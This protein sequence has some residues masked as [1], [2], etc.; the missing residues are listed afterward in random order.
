M[1]SKKILVKLCF[2]GSLRLIMDPQSQPSYDLNIFPLEKKL[3]T[4]KYFLTFKFF[5]LICNVTHVNNLVKTMMN[6]RG[7]DWIHV[8]CYLKWDLEFL[9]SYPI[10]A[11][12]KLYSL[13]CSYNSSIINEIFN[14]TWTYC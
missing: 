3:A 1:S 13:L 2:Y 6:F 5:N 14:Y 9:R 10:R 4:S 7:L 11:R 12:K 8:H